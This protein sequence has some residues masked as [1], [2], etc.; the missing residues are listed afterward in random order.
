MKQNRR[1]FLFTTAGL[2]NMGLWSPMIPLAQLMSSKSFAQSTAENDHLFVVVHPFGGMDITCG[3]DP[4]ILP[5]GAT[6]TDMFLEYTPDQIRSAGT[7]LR[8]APAAHPLL[9]HAN[10]IAVINGIA[11]VI[12]DSDPGHGTALTYITSGKG[13]GNTTSLPVEIGATTS[14]GPYGVIMAGQNISVGNRNLT[15]VRPEDI[16]NGNSNRRDNRANTAS[17]IG[18]DPAKAAAAMA[19]E[20]KSN[21]EASKALQAF[22]RTTEI[23]PLFEKKLTDASRMAAALG[24]DIQATAAALASGAVKQAFMYTQ[25][26][27]FDS[28]SGHERTHMRDQTQYWQRAS[29]LMTLFKNLPYKDTSESLFSK[30]TFLFTNE[31][32]RTPAL[33]GAIGRG[34]GKDHNPRT[35][36]VV[37][38]GRGVKGGQTIGA[39]VLVTRAESENN[40][41]IHAGSPFDFQTGQALDFYSGQVDLEQIKNK[42]R[43][44][45]PEN[46]AATIR[47]IFGVPADRFMT[48][49]KSTRVI[50]QIKS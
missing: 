49:S 13:Q 3:L 10:D 48:V 32:S 37:L 21:S 45:R 31:F 39:S 27:N 38:A 25:N 50:S 26:G 29:D 19:A 33:N 41:P 1:D 35:N 6:Q 20:N 18:F 28:H 12:D 15:P 4:Q 40:R 2:L 30:T 14:V 43:F 42:T 11:M 5:P 22:G 36:S 44:I 23:R 16:R 8:L 7:S 9:A 47:D 46:V 34:A 17:P 24:A